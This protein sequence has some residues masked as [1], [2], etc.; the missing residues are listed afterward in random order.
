VRRRAR[1]L[2]VPTCSA[3]APDP[4]APVSSS[5]MTGRPYV[6]APEAT[7]RAPTALRA[8]GP[9]MRAVEPPAGAAGRL[10]CTFGPLSSSGHEEHPTSRRRSHRCVDRSIN[11]HSNQPDPYDPS[12]HLTCSEPTYAFAPGGVDLDVAGQT[13]T[14]PLSSKDSGRHSQGGPRP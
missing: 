8:R 11:Q 14:T 7:L 4:V 6:S 2:I 13:L 5:M 1:A 12:S 3:A 10:R 9:Q